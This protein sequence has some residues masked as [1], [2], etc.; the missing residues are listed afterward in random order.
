MSGVTGANLICYLVCKNDGNIDATLKSLN[1]ANHASPDVVK[2]FENFYIPDLTLHIKEIGEKY[3][4]KPIVNPAFHKFKEPLSLGK[5]STFVEGQNF[6]PVLETAQEVFERVLMGLIEISLNKKV[7]I[8]VITYHK[9]IESVIATLLYRDKNGIKI[10][11]S[12][13]AILRLKDSKIELIGCI[14]LEIIQNGWDE[15][16]EF[17]D[18][19]LLPEIKRLSI[20]NNLALENSL[21]NGL[22]KRLKAEDSVSTLLEL[23]IKANLPSLKKEEKF[24]LI[25]EYKRFFIDLI[26]NVLAGSKDFALLVQ[27]MLSPCSLEI[28]TLFLKFY[29]KGGILIFS[30][31]YHEYCRLHY[32]QEWKRFV[33]FWSK[34]IASDYKRG[35][36]PSFPAIARLIE[37]PIVGG[38]PIKDIFPFGDKEQCF[39]I[40]KELAKFG[41]VEAG[42]CLT[43]VYLYGTILNSE[44]LTLSVEERIQGLIELAEQGFFSAQKTLGKIYYTNRLGK[45]EECD[46]F[47]EERKNGLNRLR[48]LEKG[49]FNE[50]VTKAIWENGFGTP[51]ENY[52]YN[53]TK[54]ER[55]AFLEKRA[56]KGDE[57]ALEYLWEMVK[58]NTL[59]NKNFSLS[60]AISLGLTNEQR[61]AKI[62]EIRKIN[63]K[64]ID[65]LFTDCVWK[66]CFGEISLGMTDEQ[67]LKLLEDQAFQQNNEVAQECL[68]PIYQYDTFKGQKL[69]MS[70]DIRFKKIKKLAEMGN[71]NGCSA[72][73]S[74]NSIVGIENKKMVTL[75][76]M[77]ILIETLIQGN[78]W[79]IGRTT[80]VREYGEPWKTPIEVIFLL[81]EMLKTQKF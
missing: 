24:K 17:F 11:D 21:S 70:F 80:L 42:H 55:I 9:V 4:S 29:E 26:R 69:G 44:K 13:I 20:D 34:K 12:G 1:L 49:Q 65:A 32:P 46:F 67:C 7:H 5:N 66:N 45:N 40:L 2:P 16:Q 3:Q 36:F 75:E 72:M 51:T 33:C 47:E 38:L 22:Q 53:L 19:S 27:K 59:G 39:S 58:T 78:H 57:M 77:A 48:E 73:G 25:E 68:I 63:S 15:N 74:L 50:F 41:I 54:D 18:Y 62:Q 79:K 81:L 61:L 76:R 43:Q 64:K 6:K 37:H 31:S 60:H 30:S 28:R 35:F 10:K 8:V 14:G 56:K 52:P 23:A 71:E